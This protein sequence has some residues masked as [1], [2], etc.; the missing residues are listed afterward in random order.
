MEKYIPTLSMQGWTNDMARSADYLLA[1]YLTT[2]TSDSVL[3]FQQNTSM[4]YTLKENANDPRGT[5]EQM[6]SDLK[7][8]FQ[9]VYGTTAEVYVDV[10]AEDPSKPDQYSIRFNATVYN[11]AGTPFSVGRIVYYENGVVINIAKINNG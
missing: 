5:E 10:E 3:H 6:E 7:T 8:K 1:C 9:S 11:D 2:L 4:Q